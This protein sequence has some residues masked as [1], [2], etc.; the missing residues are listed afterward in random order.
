MDIR[1]NI[2]KLLS[3]EVRLA[4]DEEDRLWGW[5]ISVGSLLLLGFVYM[6][7]VTEFEVFTTLLY[8]GYIG[9]Y[10]FL[11]TRN[12]KQAIYFVVLSFLGLQ[13]WGITQ[14]L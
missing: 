14:V 2:V 9:L 1:F 3:D 8:G 6:L 13:L 5:V 12:K 11:A 4:A 10:I 7:L